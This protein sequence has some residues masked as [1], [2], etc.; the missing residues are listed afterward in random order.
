VNPGGGD[1][2][3]SF[4]IKELILHPLKFR[5]I[6]EVQLS[7]IQ[8]IC[9]YYQIECRLGFFNHHYHRMD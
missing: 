2:F 4:E 9:N 3:Y 8:E 5:R 7:Q 1:L 6:F